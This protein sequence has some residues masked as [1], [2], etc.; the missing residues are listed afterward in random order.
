MTQ[1]RKRIVPAVVLA[2]LLGVWGFFCI[3]INLE[4]PPVP[5]EIYYENEPF[6]IDGICYTLLD[7]EVVSGEETK[8]ILGETD[9]Y[10]YRD[11]IENEDPACM[12]MCLVRMRVKNTT[13]QI[14]DNATIGIL[15]S[16][17]ITPA[18]T[19]STW[20]KDV[21]DM[22]NSKAYGEEWRA[23]DAGEENEWILPYFLDVRWMSAKEWENIE[24]A[25]FQFIID[26]YPIDLRFACTP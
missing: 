7:S 23:L 25:P 4:H 9:F 10:R 5:Q 15:F 20:W 16:M 6:T 18:D 24:N 11:I 21:A 17:M 3:K 22:Y 14:V 1:K 26:D 2:V 13:A 12:R 8:T 19:L